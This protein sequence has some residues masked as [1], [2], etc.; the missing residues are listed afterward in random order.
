MGTIWNLAER[1]ISFVKEIDS[2]VDSF[3]Q[4]GEDNVKVAAVKREIGRQTRGSVVL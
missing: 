4:G 3:L 1:G 2:M